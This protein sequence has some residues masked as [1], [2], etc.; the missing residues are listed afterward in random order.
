MIASAGGAMDEL[1][2]IR[3]ERGLSQQRLAELAK[4]DKVT[5]VH[6]EGGKVSPKVET[7][8]KLATALEVEVADFFPK[9]Q[10]PLFQE[11]PEQEP[12]GERRAAWEAAVDKAQRLRETGW[13][14]MWKALAEWRAS[15]NRGEPYATRRKYLDDMG[16][17][18][19]EV[20]DADRAVGWAYIQAA[21]RTPGGSEASFPSYLQEESRKTGQFY[22]ELLGLVKGA[23]LSVL[24]GDAA[25]AAKQATAEQPAAEHVQPEGRPRGVE[26]PRVA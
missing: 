22:G 14:R 17:L 15:K 5:I 25:T 13:A 7:L 20:Y 4:V 19:Q 26:E 9:A 21:S 10:A 2:R 11:P 23:R 6:I 8:E 18:L 1:R 12:A 3:K 24:T 16:N